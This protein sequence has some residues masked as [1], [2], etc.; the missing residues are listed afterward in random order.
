M[1]FVFK[2]PNLSTN[3]DSGL[4][5]DNN[6][7]IDGSIASNFVWKYADP[8]SSV[9]TGLNQENAQ[10]CAI[11]N[12]T[13]TGSW[14]SKAKIIGELA[15][16]AKRIVS[17]P[18]SWG[19]ITKISNCAFLGSG[20]EE[21]PRSW[22]NVV[23]LG[24]GCFSTNNIETLPSTW[25]KLTK[26]NIDS[27][28]Y[29]RIRE[30]PSSWGSITNVSGFRNNLL[31]TIPSSWN[32][33]KN[34]GKYCFT[35]NAIVSIP[36]SWGN[37]TKIDDYAFENNK[38]KRLPDHWENV[39]ELGVKSFR[40]NLLEYIGEITWTSREQNGTQ[41]SITDGYAT[42]SLSFNADKKSYS[43]H[44]NARLISSSKIVKYYEGGKIGY[45]Y[46][47]MHKYEVCYN[48]D[49]ATEWIIES[50]PPS[51]SGGGEIMTRRLHEL[52]KSG[53]CT[54]YIQVFHTISLR[55]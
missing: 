3:G 46:V 6:F 39:R 53:T 43:Y 29:N 19:S 51:S 20:L 10:K 50:G 9:I 35:R 34:I 31:K 45:Y 12:C 27:F 33:I 42:D 17:I 30:L 11:A 7:N 32:Y 24:E 36:S 26:I 48:P 54:L 18:S 21:I 2:R 5:N 49:G 55:T 38:L 41:N 23:F 16:S 37:V 15:F 25:G 28:A 47:V 40:N 1:N 44:K 13:I 8:S 22:D 14:P 52:Y 4:E